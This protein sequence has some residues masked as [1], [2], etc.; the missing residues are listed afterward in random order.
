MLFPL[1]AHGNKKKERKYI[2]DLL[3]ALNNPTKF[4]LIPIKIQKFKL[5]MFDPVVTLKYIQGH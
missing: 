2:H 5:K 1:S 3:D 4:H